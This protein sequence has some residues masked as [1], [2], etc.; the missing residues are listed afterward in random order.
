MVSFDG[1]KA[2]LYWG[3]YS[4]DIVSRD[5]ITIA[6]KT[7]LIIF[8]KVS[9]ATALTVNWDPEPVPHV[10]LQR[11]SGP[12]LEMKAQKNGPHSASPQHG[13]A[14]RTV[15]VHKSRWR[16]PKKKDDDVRCCQ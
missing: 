3:S 7:H 8:I 6:T 16:E 13:A 1:A 4:N 10:Q 12:V 15:P 2:E 11:N 5:A 14:Q 9:S